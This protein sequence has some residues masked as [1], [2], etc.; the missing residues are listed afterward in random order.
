MLVTLCCDA[1]VCMCAQM[2]CIALCMFSNAPVQ[3]QKLMN[4]AR[5]VFFFLLY[6][7]VTC[8]TTESHVPEE[9]KKHVEVEASIITGRD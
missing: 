6:E 7:V 9:K 1:C 4:G 3:G 2:V 5:V 8:R